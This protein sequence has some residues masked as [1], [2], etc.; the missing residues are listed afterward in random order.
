MKI[1]D[2]EKEGCAIRVNVPYQPSIIDI[3][4][5]AFHAVKSHVG[6]GSVKHGQ[7]NSAHNQ[8]NQHNGGQ[9][10][11]APKIIAVFRHR[12]FTVFFFQIR[13]YRNAEFNPV[14]K[15]IF[16]FAGL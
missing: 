12:V 15:G 9:R 14:E 2:N 16:V 6:M 5:D 3:T 1:D 8:Y 10:A 11:E 4:H 13:N 7:E